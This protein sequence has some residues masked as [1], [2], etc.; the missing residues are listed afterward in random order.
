[1]KKILSFTI[2]LI[3]LTIAFIFNNM[4]VNGTILISDLSAQ[5]YHFLL[6][7]M[8]F[9]KGEGTIFYTFDFGLGGS[10]Y[11]IFVYYLSSITNIFL[12]FF[13][14][15]NLYYY[16]FLT[17]IFKI[18][19]CGFTMYKYLEYNFKLKKYILVFSTSYALSSYIL[20]NY[21]QIMWL[22]CY[23]LAPLILLGIDKI[24]N[25][26]KFWL[27]YFTLTLAI[28]TNYYMGYV[29]CFF[30][31]LY[32]IYKVTIKKIKF[33]NFSTFLIVSFLSGMTTMVTNFTAFTEII[34]F[35]RINKLENGFSSDF[36]KIISGFFMGNE[37]EPIINFTYPRLYISILMILFLFL[38]FLN[39]KIDK[40]EKFVSGLFL[41][42]FLIFILVKPLNNIWHA[43]SSPIGFNFR[44]VFLVNIFII[45][46]CCK[47]FENLEYVKKTDYL[48]FIYIFF[49]LGF[50]VY[51]TKS[52]VIFFIL[53]S[54]IFAIIYSLLFYFSKIKYIIF[55]FIIE[56]S[57]NSYFVYNNFDTLNSNN[58]LINK[59]ILNIVNEI[60]NNEESKFYRMDLIN[61]GMRTNDNILYNYHSASS[62]LSTI[63]YS[64]LNFFKNISYDVGTNSYHF[65]NNDITN[66]L[67]GIKY[68]A[69]QNSH[70]KVLTSYNGYNVYK[71]ENALELAY[72]VNDGV[73]K[74]LICDSS[75]DCQEK[76]LNYMTGNDSDIYKEINVI[77]NEQFTFEAD[78][79]LN[80]DLYI[81]IE[82]KY[83]DDLNLDIYIN[84]QYIRNVNSYNYDIDNVVKLGGYLSNQFNNNENIEIKLIDNN[85]SSY[86]Q[87]VK[88]YSYNYDLYNEDIQLLKN[89][90]LEI[91][92]FSDE[93]IIGNIDG[94]GVL[95]T[96]IPYDENWHI[97][98]DGKLVDSYKIFDM[99]LG[100]DIDPGVHTIEFKYEIQNKRY[101]IIISI[102]SF[103]FVILYSIYRKKIY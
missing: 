49:I 16:I 75:F 71:N 47:S 98:I 101:G 6:K 14:Y 33:K 26:N 50:I 31:V 79:E 55:I 25:E 64:N 78:L 15:E 77:K 69:D 4:L 68:Y 30:C 28:F 19:L 48:L 18:C 13:S 89:K 59:D 94:G 102:L 65:K 88:I 23:V 74:E 22:D 86:D 70:D 39:K 99:F 34:K 35:G 41:L 52:N 53:L 2:P 76:M 20:T 37:M 82:L 32:Y 29:I 38:Y 12:K 43:L 40:K 84:D 5:Y 62:W 81:Y 85:N 51:I 54:F 87:I 91:K 95:F 11:S 36:S 45:T 7:F 72:I 10:M 63:K 9:L 57:L 24:I 73:K 96:S 58:D 100:A 90:Q 83:I 97:F 1:M 61:L 8:Y 42:L 67:F 80:S 60:K 66:S 56:I 44:Y 3:I 27:Y 17:V 103:A 92:Y 21:F 93:Y 46:L